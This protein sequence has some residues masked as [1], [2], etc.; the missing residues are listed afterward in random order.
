V[1]PVPASDDLQPYLAA[2]HLSWFSG[3]AARVFLVLTFALL[4]LACVALLSTMRSIQSAERDKQQLLLTATE[5]NARKLES[6]ILSAQTA[7][8]LT[9]NVLADKEPA[10]NICDRMMKFLGASDS[11]SDVQYRVFAKDGSSLCGPAG[12]QTL[13]FAQT[14]DMTSHADAR[15][16]SAL[17]GMLVRTKSHD[18]SVT[19]VA[20]YGK[21]ALAQLTQPEGNKDSLAL[22][23]EQAGRRISVYGREARAPSN[24]IQAIAPVGTTGMRMALSVVEQPRNIIQTLAMLLPLLMWAAAAV[25]GWIV[26]RWLLI[27]PLVALR[28]AVANYEPGQIIHPPRH[29]RNAPIEIAELGAAFQAMSKD[30]ATHEGEMQNA[31]ERQT[32]LTREVHHR[33]KNN[34][35]IISSLI[36]LHSRHAQ[37]PAASDAYAAIQRRV[38]ALAV[39]QRN[40]YAEMETNRG[41]SAPPLISEIASSLR[42]SAPSVNGKQL[43]IEVDS[44]QL[45]LH[46]DVAAPVAFLIAELTDLVIALQAETFIR[47]ALL[48]HPSEKDRA[49]L[50]VVSPLFSKAVLDQSH[51]FKLYE[52]V[53]NGLSRQLRMPLEH[54]GENGA[55]QIMLPTMQ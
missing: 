37:E 23:L 16:E 7:S 3:T 12:K 31:L 52:R 21:R 27:Q 30:V 46:Q 34:L 44:D 24:A 22:T 9:V 39:V 17:G 55:F 1:N 43:G 25:I 15:I 8:T 18:G 14:L 51:H 4:P 47:I 26:V 32:K 2:R 29:F 38:D 5:Q 6:D 40:H 48:S 50:R 20:F 53:L 13:T 45:W 42:A 36:S 33:V 35:Q 54:D 11:G 41:V 49:I 10:G 19:A 28:R